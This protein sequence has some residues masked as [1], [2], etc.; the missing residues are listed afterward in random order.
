MRR[1]HASFFHPN[2]AHG[3]TVVE[4]VVVIVIIGILLALTATQ[5]PRLQMSARDKERQD[6]IN[7]IATTLEDIYKNGS[8]GGK[9]IPA[10]D[11]TTQSKPLGYPSVTLASLPSDTQSSSITDAIGKSGLSSPLKNGVNS[12]QATSSTSVP[13]FPSIVDA[14]TDVYYYQ[15][16]KVDNTL[17]SLAN[18]TNT[19]QKTIAPRLDDECVKF[20]LYYISEIDG[21]MKVKSSLASSSGGL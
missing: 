14:T 4:T 7:I 19:N 20:K 21:A 5:G 6:D 13:S 1:R 17:C 12:L 15:P 11:G 10:G 3:F 9:T 16:L 18:S 8:V 2:N